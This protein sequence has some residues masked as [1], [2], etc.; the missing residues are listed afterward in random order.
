MVSSLTVWTGDHDRTK[1]DGEMSHAVCDKT[2]HQSF[3][4]PRYDNDIAILKLCKPLMFTEGKLS[5]NYWLSGA[6]S[7]IWY[8][9]ISVVRPIC[10]PD[11]TQDYDNVN[12]VVTGWGDLT[13]GGSQPDILQEV[14]VRTQ[15]TEQCRGQYGQ[16][17]ISDNMICAAKPGKDSC[18]GDSGGP[19]AVQGQGG[20][21]RQVGV[22][23][24][25]RGCARP[26][27][28]GVYT[29]VTSFLPWIRQRMT[30]GVPGNILSHPHSQSQLEVCC[31][32]FVTEIQYL[33]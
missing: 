26:G 16:N 21:F 5:L 12:A 13:R 14:T 11:P 24:F 25:G 32:I 18:W 33:I 29:R 4:N 2:E 20:E 3:N 23:S 8:L 31:M 19:L 28:P 22:V 15:S 17:K 6:R 30:A 1:N 7:D 27:Y 9:L 10:L